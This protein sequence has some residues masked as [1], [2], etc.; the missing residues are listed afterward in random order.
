MEARFKT[1]RKVKALRLTL[2]REQQNRLTIREFH[3]R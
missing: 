2:T 3:F 1:R